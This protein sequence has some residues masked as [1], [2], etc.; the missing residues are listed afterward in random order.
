MIALWITLAIAAGCLLFLAGF[1]T[2]VWIQRHS[3]QD[4][5][6]PKIVISEKV[7]VHEV[8]KVIEVPSARP[9]QG[10]ST[11]L[12]GT[13]KHVIIDPTEREEAEKMTGLINQLPEV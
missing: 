4:R 1:Y 6:V 7:V 10:P 9:R 2:G 12:M 11:P 13:N 8:P 5:E 3:Y